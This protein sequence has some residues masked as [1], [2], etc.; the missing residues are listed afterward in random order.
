MNLSIHGEDTPMTSELS[1]ELHEEILQR[2]VE[3]AKIAW[4]GNPTSSIQVGQ[5]SE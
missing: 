4:E 1:E 2:A 3:L 5:R